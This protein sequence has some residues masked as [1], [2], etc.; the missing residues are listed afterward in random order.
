MTSEKLKLCQYKDN[1]AENFEKPKI[2]ALTAK[3]IQKY[4][5]S[6]YSVCS[7]TLADSDI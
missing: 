5:L 7:S 4:F 1:S 2:L 3:S 6:S